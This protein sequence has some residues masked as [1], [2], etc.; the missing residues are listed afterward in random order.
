[1]KLDTDLNKC[2]EKPSKDMKIM[3]QYLVQWPIPNFTLLRT[4]TL[5]TVLQCCAI[6]CDVYAT[7]P[8]ERS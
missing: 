2:D 1:M 8:L 4:P 7:V 3:I 5:A 6:R